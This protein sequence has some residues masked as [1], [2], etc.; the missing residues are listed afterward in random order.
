MNLLRRALIFPLYASLFLAAAEAG[1]KEDCPPPDASPEAWYIY[2]VEIDETTLPEGVDIYQ[3]KEGQYPVDQTSYWIKN[4]GETPLFI[5]NIPPELRQENDPAAYR[6]YYENPEN[7]PEISKIQNSQHLV[8]REEQ[9]QPSAG[10]E[11]EAVSAAWRFCHSAPLSVQL[12][13]TLQGK[14]RLVNDYPVKISNGL[15]PAKA[16]RPE[17]GAPLTPLDFPL[18]FQYGKEIHLV[19]ATIHFANNPFYDFANARKI[20][21][22]RTNCFFYPGSGQK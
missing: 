14:H 13:E 11:E 7:F 22:A 21:A 15:I 9:W 3:Q 1:A 16:G 20:R 12:A 8:Y 5:G 10:C 17:N 2:T 4:T 19:K 18:I 6:R